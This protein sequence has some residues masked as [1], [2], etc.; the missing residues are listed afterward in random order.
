ML[1]VFSFIPNFCP[2]C[3][4]K[5]KIKNHSEKKMDYVAG[6]GFECTCGLKYQ[7]CEKEDILSI[8]NDL[9]Y[10]DGGRS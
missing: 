1:A 4:E 9:N 7:S 8:A 5:T 10:Y 6:A 2:S 3:G